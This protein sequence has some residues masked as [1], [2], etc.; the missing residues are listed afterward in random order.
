MAL[1]SAEF[2]PAFYRNGNQFTLRVDHELRPGK[3]RLYTNIY[4]TTSS[5]LNGEL[6]PVFDRPTDKTTWFG[7][8]NHTHIFS[9]N[10]LNEIRLGVMRGCRAAARP[11]IWAFPQS[12]LP[13]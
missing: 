11:P 6:R 10:M 5:S 4:R 12:T 7:S 13:A 9:A 2:V 8:L 3:D 1:G